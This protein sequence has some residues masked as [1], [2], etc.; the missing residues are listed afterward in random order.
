MNEADI[1]KG[2]GAEGIERLT[3][4]FYRRVRRDDLI[5]PMYPDQDWEGAE[6]R[7]AG[8]LKFRLGGDESYLAERGHPRLR[9]R[10][11]PFQI[12]EAERDRWVQLMGEAVAEEKIAPEHAEPL[13][14]FF[15]QVADFLRNR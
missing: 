15:V 5:G 11:A 2:I 6:A 13:M 1:W 12:G 10:H 4:A 7:L 8:F 14:L 9:M 3:A